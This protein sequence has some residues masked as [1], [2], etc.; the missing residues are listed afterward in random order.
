M[1]S[2]AVRGG[3]AGRAHG[4]QQLELDV[5]LEA[6]AHGRAECH[7]GIAYIGEIRLA[8]LVWMTA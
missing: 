1:T 7:S 3:R 6:K 4:K 8:S 5:G 2:A